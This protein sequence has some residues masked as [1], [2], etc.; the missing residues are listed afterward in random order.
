MKSAL[1]FLLGS[2]SLIGCATKE[3]KT[4]VYKNIQGEYVV[5]KE[6]KK[7]IFYGP[8]DVPGAMD[9]R[10]NMSPDTLRARENGMDQASRRAGH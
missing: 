4:V 5:P 10:N 7:G 8:S 3:K 1:I 9:P 2:L 6:K